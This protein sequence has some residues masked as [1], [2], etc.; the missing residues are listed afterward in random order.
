MHTG[1]QWEPPDWRGTAWGTAG[2]TYRRREG[3]TSNAVMQLEFPATN[4]IGSFTGEVI[5]MS[6]YTT[7]ITHLMQLL[8][9]TKH[10]T[11]SGWNVGYYVVIL[12]GK[13]DCSLWSVKYGSFLTS[14]G[15]DFTFTPRMHKVSTGP[16]AHWRE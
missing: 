14:A 9:I 13:N 11:D 7:K 8:H 3:S 6:V 5:T 10:E 16:N 2:G 15:S 4:M 12:S 1:W